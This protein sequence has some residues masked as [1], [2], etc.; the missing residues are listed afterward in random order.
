MNEWR[1]IAVMAGGPSAEQAV[2][3]ASGR[4]VVAALASRGYR[5][6]EVD[7]RP[8]AWRLPEMTEVVFLALHGTYGEDGTIQ[9]ELDDLGIPYT[10]CGA[11]ASACAFDKVR[12]K[13]A[14]QAQGIPTPRFGV[15]DETNRDFP[16]A[17]NLPL[18]LKPACQGSSVGVEILESKEQWAAA[19]ARVAAFGPALAEEFIEGREI[20][21]SIVGRRLLPIV[22]I[23]PKSGYYDYRNKYTQG[24]T[25]YICPAPFDVGL[26]RAIREAAE[27]AF[28]AI[29][30]GTCARVDMIV[31]GRELFVLEVNTIPGMT[32][33]S[34]LPKSAAAGG[35]SFEELCHHLVVLALERQGA[36]LMER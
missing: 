11:E 35:L 33:T 4:A 12:T 1:N 6:T 19:V 28:A 20:T 16:D 2:S 14:F 13:H 8:G 15:C 21:V 25:E 30:G 3:L 10:G 24:A 36:E 32:A 31:R 18:V 29:G 34:L 5:V 17:L 27:G 22:E 26:E 7:P 23:C 9:R